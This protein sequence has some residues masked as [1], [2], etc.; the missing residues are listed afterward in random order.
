MRRRLPILLLL[1]VAFA[2]CV[3]A[4]NDSTEADVEAINGL[5]G[6]YVRA[7][8]TESTESVMAVYADGAVLM[9]A[10]QPAFNGKEEIPRWYDAA[11]QQ[12]A[13]DLSFQMAEVV[14]A[15]EWAFARWTVS[16]TLTPQTGGD[17][18]SVSSKGISILQRQ[19]D[20]SWKIARFMFNRD[21][22]G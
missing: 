12:S 9:P 4:S 21:E 7:L 22:A 6:D 18:A 16:G 1:V 2:A 15:G 10:D 14:V 13:Y 20:G 17:P 11:F 8:N 3:P 5:I 19:A